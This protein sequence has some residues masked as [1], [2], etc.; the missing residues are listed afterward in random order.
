VPIHP[1]MCPFVARGHE[2]S[3][4]PLMRTQPGLNRPSH[5]PVQPSRVLCGL[6]W[7]QLGLRLC[8][9]NRTRLSGRAMELNDPPGE[10][11]DVIPED[12]L[13]ERA[14]PFEVSLLNLNVLANSSAVASNFP[15]VAASA[16]HG[17]SRKRRLLDEIRAFDPAVITLQDVDEFDT[18]WSRELRHAGF[19][20]IISR[21]DDDRRRG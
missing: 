9:L 18:F 12:V 17:P 5:S 1:R 4:L 2:G 16:L 11:I 3:A 13:E 20:C 6:W 7:H 8:W 14:L 15:L 21:R 10:L 19:D